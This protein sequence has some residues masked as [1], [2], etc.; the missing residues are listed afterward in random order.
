MA[1]ILVFFWLRRRKAQKASMHAEEP[2]AT[3]TPVTVSPPYG[4][5]TRHTTTSLE[6]NGTAP[7]T[8][9]AM[10]QWSCGHEQTLVRPMPPGL[11]PC[12]APCPIC[13]RPGIVAQLVAGRF[14]PIGP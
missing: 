14:V 5:T 1:G 11:T 8:V 9:G 3:G 10:T 4:F 7:L 13:G 6:R 12:T 2:I